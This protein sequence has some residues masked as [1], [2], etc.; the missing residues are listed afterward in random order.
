MPSDTPASSLV[1]ART[2]SQ[3]CSAN[4]SASA[5]RSPRPRSSRSTHAGTLTSLNNLARLQQAL[6]LTDDAL[7]NRRIRTA[8]AEGSVR[9]ANALLCACKCLL[10]AFRSML[11]L[12]LEV[13]A[14][15]CTVSTPGLDWTGQTDTN[16]NNQEQTDGRTDKWTD[17][18]PDRRTD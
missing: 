10:R 8:E 18:Q 9:T 5:V 15:A 16:R 12:R 6:G 14:R 2:T 11:H 7:R 17:R 4:A 1:A 13:V 3:C